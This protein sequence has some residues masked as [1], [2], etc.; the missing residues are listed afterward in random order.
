[1][2]E[3]N[4]IIQEFT[5]GEYK[6]GFV[7]D[8]EQ[9]FIPKGLNE[10]II[11]QISARKEEPEWLLEFRLDAFRK[12]Q[13]MPEP[14]WAHLDMPKI[15]YQDIIYYAAPKKDK[16]RPKEIDPKLQ[17]TF[18]K[19]GIPLNEREVLA[20]VV[21]V[22]VLFEDVLDFSLNFVFV[23]AGFHGL[24]TAS[25]GFCGD[26]AGMLDDVDLIL[27]FYHAQ[28][29]EDRCGTAVLVHRVHLLDPSDEAFLD[30]FHVA[31]VFR[32]LIAVEEEGVAIA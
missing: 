15:D 26:V 13:A 10:D 9:E 28:G 14:Q 5:S 29:V 17:E 19:L 31:L 23:H 2:S 27:G 16:D 18:D 30:G 22:V 6:E 25:E 4:K 21:A 12:W 3:D 11:R 7:T 1:M 32:V 8:V 20:G 24:Q